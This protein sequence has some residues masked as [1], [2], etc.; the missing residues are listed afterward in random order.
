MDHFKKLFATMLAVLM[1]AAAGPSA[2]GPIYH[3]DI[4]TTSLGTGNAWLGFAAPAGIPAAVRDRL[5]AAFSQAARDP[6][7]VAAIQRIGSVPKELSGEAFAAAV[8]Q[9]V[10]ELRELNKTLKLALD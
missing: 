5:V 2:A 8:R 9:E 3:V 4:D 7:V 10:S 6:E 1:L